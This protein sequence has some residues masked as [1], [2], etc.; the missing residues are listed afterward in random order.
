[1]KGRPASSPAEHLLGP[2]VDLLARRLRSAAESELSAFGLRPRHVVALTVL[3]DAGEQSQSDLAQSLN[4]D[5]TNL[6]A[7]LNDLEAESL[8]ERRRSA[9]DRRR[10]DVILTDAG[11][12][13]LEEIEHALAG[14]ERRLFASLD[15]AEQG[16]LRDLL[17]RAAAGEATS[18]AGA[19]V[20]AVCLESDAD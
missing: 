20:E 5:P 7:L 6:V 15:A 2:L 17:Q 14:L 3:R 19:V 11:V 8:V 16:T 4:I 18:C 10:H 13:R 1:M 12:R 9:A